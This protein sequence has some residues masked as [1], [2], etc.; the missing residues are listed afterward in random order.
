MTV[1]P[2]L[3][4]GMRDFSP[5][6]VLA[7][8]AVMNTIEEEFIRF[9]FLPLST[10]ALE[11]IEVLAGK[12]GEET[13]R[14]TFKVLKRGEGG[15][16]AEADLALRPDL[17][18]PLARYIA[19]HPE[20]T[21]PFKRYQ[22]EKAWRAERP[23][24]GRYREFV[25]CDADI[26]G[27]HS[28][29]A[30]AEIIA[31]THRILL[32]LGFDGFH[33]RINHRELINASFLACGIPTDLIPMVAVAVDKIDKIGLEGVKNELQ[34]ENFPTGHPK[35]LYNYLKTAELFD[36]LAIDGDNKQRIKT[37]Q[38]LLKDSDVG[39]HALKD[40]AQI[41]EILA[42]MEIAEERLLYDPY[43]IR[44]MDYYTGPVFESFVDEPRIGSLTGGGRY[45]GLIGIFKGEPVPA[46][47]TTIGFERVVDVLAE[48]GRMP[49]P[50]TCIHVLVTVFNAE[51][52][53][54]SVELT[55][56]LRQHGVACELYL[57]PGE[58]L[59]K[60]LRYADERKIPLAVIMGPD[61][62]AA[63]R[64]QL[65]CLASREQH[66]VARADLYWKIAEILNL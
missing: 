13:D 2:H 36:F 46:T 65:K 3:P 10:P 26:V 54:H 48:L 28:L 31:L 53:K 62:L 25:Q 7:R 16:A 59:A 41:L 57:E 63:G 52:A 45:D 49:Q 11:R 22:M 61:E 32:A 23:Q 58:K 1:E 29:Y 9:G 14:L 51:M 30:D 56:L 39:L 44:G 55:N 42:E 17:T 50:K 15:K 47:G 21:F 12:S 43:L 38:K 19:M 18:V 27:C 34:D 37:A 64:V 60:Q 35:K 24:R 40:I 5:A 8:K 6:E 20:T 66:D 4:K 33:I